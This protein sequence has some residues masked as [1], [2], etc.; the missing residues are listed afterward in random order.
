[1]KRISRTKSLMLTSTTG[2]KKLVQEAFREP[3]GYKELQ[4][5]RIFKAN[6]S[7]VYEMRV[8]PGRNPAEHP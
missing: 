4:M 6:R 8:F 3:R 5:Y 7:A 2:E 1:M